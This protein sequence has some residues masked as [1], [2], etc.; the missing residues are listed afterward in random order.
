MKK[1][2]RSMNHGKKQKIIYLW[3]HLISVIYYPEP[4]KRVMSF[5]PDRLPKTAP[6]G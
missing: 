3:I 2:I 4:E 1:M 6:A 5:S